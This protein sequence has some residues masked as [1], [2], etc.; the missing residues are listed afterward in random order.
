VTPVQQTQ[1]PA[2][3][4]PADTTPAGTTAA[5]TTAANAA[6]AMV[7]RFDPADAALLPDGDRE[8]LAR[9]RAVLGDIYPLFYARPVH[10]VRG[11]GARLWDA[12]GTEYLDA[13]NNVPAVGH[14]NPRVAT[15][16]HEQLTRMNTHTRYLQD[17]IVTFASD[18]EFEKITRS[19]CS[20]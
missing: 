1:T 11:A 2:E 8:L 18:P 5:N 13:Y 9:R 7:N 4:T 10:V 14:A 15:A 3:T 6:T 20:G 12:D 19:R 17:G 16:V